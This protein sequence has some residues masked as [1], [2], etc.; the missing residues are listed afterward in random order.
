MWFNQRHLLS[1]VF[2]NGSSTLAVVELEEGLIA[3]FC[4]FGVVPSTELSLCQVLHGPENEECSESACFQIWCRVEGELYT[5][6]LRCLCGGFLA[7]YSS[8]THEPPSQWVEFLQSGSNLWHDNFKIPVQDLFCCRRLATFC[9]TGT[10]FSPPRVLRPCT[11][12]PVFCITESQAWHFHCQLAEPGQ[13]RGCDV[14]KELQFMSVALWQSYLS[15]WQFTQTWKCAVQTETRTVS[16]SV[17]V[18]G[19]TWQVV[20]IPYANIPFMS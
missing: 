5:S 4:V 15:L 3:R 8:A 2:L 17:R 7:F 12:R 11:A 14:T 6:Q 16:V 20:R 1:T 13:S 19:K 9:H 18:H 10:Y